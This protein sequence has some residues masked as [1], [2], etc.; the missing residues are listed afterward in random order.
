[1]IGVNGGLGAPIADALRSRG[2]TVV[3]TART[4]GAADIALDIRDATAGDRLVREVL[5][6]HGRLDGVIV[7]SGIVAFGDL[8]ETDDVV[9]EEL[10]LT[11]ALGPLWLARRVAPV[12]AEHQG[13]LAAITGVVAQAPQPGMAPYTASKA[14]LSAGL[15]AV[16]REFRRRKIT[17]VEISPPHTET[18]LATRPLAGTAPTFP[19][20]LAPAAVAERVVS[21]IEGNETVVLADAF[22]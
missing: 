10:M 5:G 4:D 7:A 14:A 17:V 1:M 11:N 3:G 21:A 22:G 20:G 19:D 16:R 15:A 13:F 2:A 18:G 12:L 6:W 8:T 9:D